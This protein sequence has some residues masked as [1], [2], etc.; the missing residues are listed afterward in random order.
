[1]S[2]VS[3]H[4]D[5]GRLTEQSQCKYQQHLEIISSLNNVALFAFS[6][7]WC[8]ILDFLT[9]QALTC[10][11]LYVT[12]NSSALRTANE[13]CN[14]NIKLVIKFN[15]YVKL[16][17]IV[18]IDIAMPA[19]IAHVSPIFLFLQSGNSFFCTWNLIVNIDATSFCKHMLAHFDNFCKSTDTILKTWKK[20]Y[21]AMSTC[22]QILIFFSLFQINIAKTF[23]TL[24]FSKHKCVTIILL[25]FSIWPFKHNTNRDQFTKKA[26]QQFQILWSTV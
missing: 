14:C 18:H 22:Q 21:F 13:I 9:L 5:Q 23:C 16:V 15:E 4:Q 1:M 3:I 10:N 2:C 12:D 6:I 25:F 7:L 26:K 20:N 17:D 11:L 24:K 19:F 8:F